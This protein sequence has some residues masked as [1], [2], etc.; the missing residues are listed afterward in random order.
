MAASATRPLSRAMMDAETPPDPATAEIDAWLAI[1][2][3]ENKGDREN[4]QSGVDALFDDAP[5]SAASTIEAPANDLVAIGDNPVA[6][7]L[8]QAARSFAGKRPRGVINRA[9]GPFRRTTTR[10]A[11]AAAAAIALLL[12]G[13]MALV[14]FRDSIVGHVPALAGLYRS[15]G[16]EGES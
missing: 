9:S 6:P 7:T 2:G 10:G 5:V 3:E 1:A 12:A 14:A 4:D 8:E 15:I 13:A 11:A 16:L